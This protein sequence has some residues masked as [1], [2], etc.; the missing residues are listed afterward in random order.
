MT[1]GYMMVNLCQ[2]KASQAIEANLP[3]PRELEY[4]M[5]NA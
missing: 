3:T 2:G 4:C 1:V 5:L